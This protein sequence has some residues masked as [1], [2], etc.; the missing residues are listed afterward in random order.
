[1][2][3]P[4]G[5]DKKPQK[6]GGLRSRAF[7]SSMKA[8]AVVAALGLAGG[9]VLA[10]WQTN[11]A[12]F[13][14]TDAAAV[15]PAQPEAPAVKPVMKPATGNTPPPGSALRGVGGQPGPAIIKVTA[16]MPTG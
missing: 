8:L 11:Q 15:E 6:R 12:G 5:L 4:L 2:N 7:R 10:I 13:R 16:D 1:M 9:A 3:S 14:K